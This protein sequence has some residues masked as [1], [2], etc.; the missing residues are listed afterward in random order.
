MHPHRFQRRLFDFSWL[1]LCVYHL[2]ASVILFTCDGGTE[3]MYKLF[4]RVLG[5]PLI[6]T[7][8]SVNQTLSKF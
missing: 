5:V 3:T 2:I 1:I 6:P 8:A 4:E 7:P